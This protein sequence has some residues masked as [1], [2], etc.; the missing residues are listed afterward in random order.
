MLFVYAFKLIIH[1]V[2]CSTSDLMKVLHLTTVFCACKRHLHT[3]TLHSPTLSTCYTHQK[4]PQLVCKLLLNTE[5]VWEQT[6][7]RT[8]LNSGLN[9]MNVPCHMLYINTHICLNTVCLYT[10]HAIRRSPALTQRQH[11]Y[12]LFPSNDF[13]SLLLHFIQ[14]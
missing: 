5:F 10:V 8:C 13:L 6:C 1:Y 4:V 3:H 7:I 2:K 9:S 14:S 12:T 11:T